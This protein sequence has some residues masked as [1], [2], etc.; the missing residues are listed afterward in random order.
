MQ[1]L[2]PNLHQFGIN[3]TIHRIYLQIDCR[4][5]ILTPYNITEEKISNQVLI[6]ENVIVGKIPEAY[7]N[8]QGLNSDNALDVIE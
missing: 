2:I 5:S 3:Q 8:L 1:N 4:I 7:Y 6:A